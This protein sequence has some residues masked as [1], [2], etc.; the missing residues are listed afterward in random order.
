M[1]SKK[2]QLALT[3]YSHE[4]AKPKW[5]FVRFYALSWFV[6]VFLLSLANDYFFGKLPFTFQR[7]SVRL[8]ILFVC[9]FGY[10]FCARWF[11]RWRYKRL[12]QKQS[13]G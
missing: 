8:L 7:V 10:A 9:S 3:E 4:L 6:L 12:L 5:R 11:V 2:E 1:L 13:T